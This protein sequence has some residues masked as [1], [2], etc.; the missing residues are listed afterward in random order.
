MKNSGISR[1]Q[2]LESN[3]NNAPNFTEEE[4]MRLIEVQQLHNTLDHAMNTVS[5]TDIDKLFE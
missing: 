2:R 4:L 1:I 5:Q 3:I